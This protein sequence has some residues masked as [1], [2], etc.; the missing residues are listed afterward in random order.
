MRLTNDNALGRRASEISNVVAGAIQSGC[1]TF[2]TND[3][4]QITYLCGMGA[5]AAIHTLAAVLGNPG[6]EDQS[7]EERAAGALNATSILYAALVATRMAPDS[8]GLATR[9]DGVKGMNIEVE[10][11]PDVLVSAM[12]DFEK[13]TGRKP[14]DKLDPVMVAQ[15]RNFLEKTGDP[16]KDLLASIANRGTDGTIH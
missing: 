11:G 10:F 16:L 12:D 7:I 9:G 8:G 2:D 14:D 15:T 1:M 4:A 6:T 5:V 13:L 3:K